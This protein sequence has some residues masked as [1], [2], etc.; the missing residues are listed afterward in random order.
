MKRACAILCGCLLLSACASG[1]AGIGV[2]R[3]RSNAITT[4]DGYAAVEDRYEVTI[5]EK[6]YALAS[7]VWLPDEESAL[8][9]FYEEQ[10]ASLERIGAM[11]GFQE[12][13]DANAEDYA[14]RVT[15]IITATEHEGQEVTEQDRQYA[16][17]ILHM[18][19]LLSGDEKARGLRKT[20]DEID[21]LD[22]ASDAF[23]SHIE[24]LSEYL[25]VLAADNGQFVRDAWDISLKR[26]SE[27]T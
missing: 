6:T 9:Q 12:L 22:P 13:S 5:A 20:L 14:A 18:C 2:Q 3:L 8:R 24:R 17:E 15:P 19:F 23:A 25:P 26:G 16:R 1:N 4:D 11:V 7:D 21:G 10:R 27:G